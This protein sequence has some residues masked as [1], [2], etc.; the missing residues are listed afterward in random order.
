MQQTEVPISTTVPHEIAIRLMGFSF[1]DNLCRPEI[2]WTWNG[3]VWWT[4]P[5]KCWSVHVTHST[6]TT[7]ESRS[8]KLTVYVPGNDND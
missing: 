5:A 2:D 7:R 3:K 6:L 8:H 4:S 1:P